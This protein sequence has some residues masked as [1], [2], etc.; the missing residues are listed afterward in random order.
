MTEYYFIYKNALGK[1][2][3]ATNLKFVAEHTY[4]RAIP[5]TVLEGTNYKTVADFVYDINEGIYSPT[6]AK[7]LHNYNIY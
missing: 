1:W 7:M 3:Q 6:I 4:C 5:K 2:N